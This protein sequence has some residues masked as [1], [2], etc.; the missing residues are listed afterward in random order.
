MNK[1]GIVTLPLHF[2]YGGILQAYALQQAIKK[3]GYDAVLIGHP[4]NTAKE[5]IKGTLYKLSGVSKFINANI[6][7]LRLSVPF[8]G[9]AIR[10]NNICALIVGSD[11]VWRPCMGTD[12]N[13]NVARYFLETKNGNIRKV[14]Y[15]VSFGVDY[16][17]FTEE[18]TRKAIELVKDF[19]AISVREHSGID[20]CA[21]YLKVNN[22]ILVL[23][24][25]MLP[26]PDDYRK[27]IK[28]SPF[29]TNK[30]HCFVY[31]LDYISDSNKE[32]VNE[33]VH[34][35]V[36]IMSAKVEQ[37][38]IKKFLNSH[39]TVNNWLSSIYYSDIVVT[40][41]FHGCVFSILFH[42]EFYVMGN[43]I[44]GN[45]RIDSLL[46]T[47]GLQERLIDKTHIRR[48]SK[49]DWEKV[50]NVLDLLRNQSISFLKDSLA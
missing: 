42:K 41:S 47:F 36:E 23:D 38:T 25:T 5:I 14:A 50:D 19:D 3:I 34:G 33:I 13:E 17:D 15:A 7:I 49:I 28:V 30:K 21:K 44:G 43:D 32:V 11:Q 39:D 2:N 26:H 29:L 48:M 6:P 45:A 18:E 46:N 8:S 20:L 1:I 16:W 37:N 27:L 4:N 12:R 24:P 22:A 40:D 31:L 10:K 35:D 9:E